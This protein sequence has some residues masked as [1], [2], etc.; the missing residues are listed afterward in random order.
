LITGGT[1]PVHLEKGFYVEPAL[2]AGCTNA[3]RVA[4]E[5]IFGPVLA[6]IPYDDDDEAVAI[7]NDSDYGLY[8]YVYSAD[9][10]RAYN[11]GKQLRCGHVGLNT[12]QRNHEAPFGGFKMSGIGRDN[13]DW[14][15]DAYTEVQS[16]IWPG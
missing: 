2:L 14:G 12:A 1:R 9:T 10:A 13:G 7:A 3:M 5:E 16:I 4:R 6:V 11:I 15:L 8:D